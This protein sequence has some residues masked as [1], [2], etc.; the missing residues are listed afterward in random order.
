MR[1]VVTG[2]Y[3]FIG[4]YIVDKLAS[5]GHDV[6]IVDIVA[7]SNVWTPPAAVATVALDVATPEAEEWIAAFQPEVVFHLA[8]QALV[9]VSVED[10]I[11]DA[12]VNLLGLLRVL[13]GARRGKARKVVHS[14]SAAVYGDSGAALPLSESVRA[15]PIA[16]YGV[17]KT[18]SEMYLRS[19]HR[20]HGLEYAAL[21]YANVYGP[22]QGMGG[23]GGVVAIF[24]EKIARKES[25]RLFGDGE[26]TR[27]YVYVDDVVSANVL[28]AHAR[29]NAVCNVSTGIQTSNARLIELLR[30]VTKQEITVRREPERTGDIRYSALD[31]SAAKAL[32][33]FEP[34]VDLVQGLASTY[35]WFAAHAPTEPSAAVAPKPV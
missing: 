24:C 26:H 21:R 12:R 9:S 23:E 4:S 16:P 18:A 30:E 31:P 20:L 10:P 22:R 33:G 27:D 19:Y 35:A 5:E 25:V 1:A 15:D 28:A 29:G 34:A 13:E 14:S 11:E 7:K 8:A 6:G 17:S 2:G 3:G 32:L